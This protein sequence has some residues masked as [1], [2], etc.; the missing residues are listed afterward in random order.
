MYLYS[1]H[2]RLSDQE[3]EQS[4][5]QVDSVVFP[6]NCEGRP[7]KKR[8][9]QSCIQYIRTHSVVANIPPQDKASLVVILISDMC[10]QK[11]LL[12]SS[13]DNTT[14]QNL[15]PSATC[16][17]LATAACTARIWADNC[18]LGAR[19]SCANRW[20]LSALYKRHQLGLSNTKTEPLK[21]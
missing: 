16:E 8:R 12:S 13:A 1:E 17:A 15:L 18:S 20:D 19:G 14:G 2:M 21:T 7:Q 10:K 9:Y 5:V 4:V 6:S 3:G 11:V